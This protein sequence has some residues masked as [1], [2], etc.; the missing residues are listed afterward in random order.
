MAKYYVS[1]DGNDSW[2]GLTESEPF[3]TLEHAHSR[4][5]VTEVDVREDFVQFGFTPQKAGTE[6]SPIIFTSYGLG[7]QKPTITGRKL[8]TGWTSI[9]GGL[10]KHT[11]AGF[12]DRVK[13][14]LVDGDQTTVATFPR[15]RDYNQITG[16][17]GSSDGTVSDSLNLSGKDFTGGEVVVKKIAWVVDTMKI[18]NHSGSTLTFEGGSS[19]YNVIAGYGYFVQNHRSCCTQIG[20][21]CQEGKD[22]VMYFGAESP[23]N[24]TIYAPYLERI[25]FNNCGNNHFHGFRIEMF[26]G[27][28]DNTNS[29]PAVLLS[30]SRNLKFINPEF[31]YIGNTVIHFE[32]NNNSGFTII[33]GSARNCLNIFLWNRHS[34][35]TPA[36]FIKDLD[37]ENIGHIVGSGGNGDIG[38]SGIIFAGATD[39]TE[40]ENIRLKNVGYN[41]INF[42][43]YNFLLKNN[44][45]ENAGCVKSD[46]GCYYTYGKGSSSSYNKETRLLVGNIGINS[47]GTNE[48]LPA[49][50]AGT[51]NPYG[52]VEAF[53]FDDDSNQFTML[54]NIGISCRYGVKF[55]NNNEMLARYNIFV[56]NKQSQILFANNNLGT[57]QNRNIDFQE[58]ILYANEGQLVLLVS[59]KDSS[60]GSPTDAGELGILDKNYYMRPSNEAGLIRTNKTGAGAGTWDLYMSQW[61]TTYGHDEN[62]KGSP[63]TSTIYEIA[64]N[65]TADS[66]EHIL[67]RIRLDVDGNEVSQPFSLEP[68]TAR[69]LLDDLGS[70]DPLPI[71]EYTVT[72]IINGNGEVSGGGT[73]EDGDSVTLEA[74]PD[75]GWQFLG[76][77]N[78]VTDNPYSFNI[79]ENVNLTAIFEEI[80]IE[81]YDIVV[82][83]IGSGSASGAGTYEQGEEVIL[84]AIPDS[85][86]KFDGWEKDEEIIETSN[87]WVFTAESDL[88]VIAKFSEVI[89]P[90]E[91]VNINV[92]QTPGGTVTGG[93]EFNEEDTVTLTA[94][95]LP[96]HTFEGWSDG[97]DVNPYVF[98]ATEDLTVSAI[99]EKIPV[100]SKGYFPVQGIFKVINH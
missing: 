39:G 4:A 86:H 30:N 7:I 42:N 9:G 5:N 18:T 73:Y 48:G 28:S 64:I 37:G 50:F 88:T 97:T 38:Y 93:G 27:G 10:Y 71:D 13:F 85:G 84:T 51:A 75:T 47:I 49:W 32:A 31:E 89:T 17:S 99:F 74:T 92:I 40:V 58:N 80:P 57:Y 3:A 16:G 12:L 56:D 2:S 65:D 91:K 60:G 94:S 6:A 35:S 70:I 53:Y 69:L 25:H 23:D 26:N 63:T 82:N 52:A 20:D 96:T 81:E 54:H 21:W 68:F 36:I 15:D 44:R 67:T 1:P 24:Y 55:H 29:N 46:G 90:V 62:S 79:T 33:G 41:G 87:P 61:R 45:I 77:S 59:T 22:I 98:P 8:L 78:D 66:I 43:G 11:D 83:I 19:A 100:P 34:S 72:I 95:P 14:L 76:W